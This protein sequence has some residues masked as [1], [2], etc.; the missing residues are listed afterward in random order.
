MIT[1]ALTGIAE[2]TQ[3]FQRLVASPSPGRLGKRCMSKAIGIMGQSVALVPV[4]TGNLR[5][6]AHVSSRQ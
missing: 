2:V 1:I 6:T 5:S 4:D 3:H